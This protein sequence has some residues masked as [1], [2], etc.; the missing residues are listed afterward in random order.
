LNKI[1]ITLNEGVVLG[2]QGSEANPLM[3]R[4]LLQQPSRGVEVCSMAFPP[5]VLTPRTYLGEWKCSYYRDFR[6]IAAQPT[7]QL[8]LNAVLKVSRRP[9]LAS[10]S[11]GLASE[12]MPEFVQ[13]KLF[14]TH[15]CCK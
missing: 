12:S 11:G 14:V 6:L 1:T 7:G 4:R 10:F 8:R 15:H 13:C 5:A 2:E 3:E 9:A